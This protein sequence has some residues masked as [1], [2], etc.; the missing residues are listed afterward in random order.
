MGQAKEKDTPKSAL[1]MSAEEFRKAVAAVD[2]AIRR[3]GNEAHD[4]RFIEGLA[5]K[6][7]VKP[8]R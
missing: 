7:A 4:A 8:S 6:Y 2:T 1:A 3:R 5:V